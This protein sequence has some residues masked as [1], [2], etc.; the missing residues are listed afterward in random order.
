MRAVDRCFNRG[1]HDAAH[2]IEAFGTRLC[3]RLTDSLSA[4]LLTVVDQ[5]WSQWEWPCGFELPPARPRAGMTWWRAGRPHHHRQL[6][7]PA[8][9][10]CEQRC[11]V[12]NVTRRV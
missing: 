8:A 10:C 6:R 12:R 4:E 3:G 5:R 11:S 9:E 1:R 7:H 2:I